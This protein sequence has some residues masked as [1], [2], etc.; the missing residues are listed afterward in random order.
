M[1]LRNALSGQQG[2]KRLVSVLAGAAMLASV[3]VAAP[4]SAG[5]AEAAAVT[6]SITVTSPQSK[7]AEG[8]KYVPYTVNVSGLQSGNYYSLK[9]KIVLGTKVTTGYLASSPLVNGANRVEAFICSSTNKAGLYKVFAS[10]SES[11]TTVASAT[12]KS[13]T[14]KVKPKWTSLN[15][16][17]T[18]GGAATVRGSLSPS[19]D[20]AGKAV[21]VYFKPKGRVSYKALGSARIGSNGSFTWKWT[22]SALGTMYVKY[23]GSTYTSIVNSPAMTI[24]ATSAGSAS[25]TR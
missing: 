9:S 1:G 5:D 25:F 8:C 20:V 6:L 23:L 13:L 7:P 4:A 17:G 14:L 21:K 12:P 24:T 15:A 19:I 3:A 11:G 16:S 10:V 18:L 2:R 22:K